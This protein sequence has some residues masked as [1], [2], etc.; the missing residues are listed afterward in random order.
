MLL[1]GAQ[2]TDF[3]AYKSP[4]RCPIYSVFPA[5]SMPKGFL[6]MLFFIVIFLMFLVQMTQAT[7]LLNAIIC[8]VKAVFTLLS[9]N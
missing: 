3:P 6:L 1:M 2:R 9:I 7:E 5:S 4:W 8:P